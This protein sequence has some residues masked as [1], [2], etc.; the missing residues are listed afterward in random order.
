MASIKIVA[1]TAEGNVLGGERIVRAGECA[2]IICP[3]DGES[4]LYTPGR[5]VYVVSGRLST[6]R[7]VPPVPSVLTLTQRI[8]TLRL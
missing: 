8:V 3:S 2:G 7:L 4:L 5:V 6:K 1:L